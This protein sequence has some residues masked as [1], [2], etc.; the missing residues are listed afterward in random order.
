MIRYSVLWLTVRFGE[1][2]RAYVDVGYS[3]IT[4]A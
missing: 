3:S 2:L 1:E 4:E